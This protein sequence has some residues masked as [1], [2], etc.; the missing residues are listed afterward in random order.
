MSPSPVTNLPLPFVHAAS[1]VVLG[2]VT[3]C[4]IIMPPGWA[5]RGPSFELAPVDVDPRT[6]VLPSGTRVVITTERASVAS[7]FGMYRPDVAFAL[8]VEGDEIAAVA[9]WCETEPEGEAIPETRFACWSLS[10]DSGPWVRFYM[11]P[12][13]DCPSRDAAHIQTLTTPACWT[14]SLEVS[15]RRFVLQ[16]AYEES[17]GAPMDDLSWFPPDGDPIL[18]A[19]VEGSRVT[20]YPLAA[21]A[22]EEHVDLLVAMTL[23]VATWRS[24]AEPD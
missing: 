9:L 11:A 12:G 3:A 14:G 23:G 17:T 15:G 21:A 6:Y 20:A 22:A 19:E 5:E 16:H 8:N 10:D 7:G 18:F 24:L 13:Q 2:S 4:T 1:L